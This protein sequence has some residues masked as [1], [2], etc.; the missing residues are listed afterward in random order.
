MNKERVTFFSIKQL[1]SIV[2]RY[3]IYFYLINIH[4]HISNGVR[5]HVYPMVATIDGF[6]VPR[7]IAII[8][9]IKK[10]AFSYTLSY[11]GLLIIIKKS[12]NEIIT[13]FIAIMYLTVG[14]WLTERRV[15]LFHSD[16]PWSTDSELFA[17]VNQLIHLPLLHQEQN[18]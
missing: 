5:M 7:Q 12:I 13:C 15:T 18:Y 9:N 17:A 10:S 16:V 11:I 4:K 2:L 1:A 3:N 8:Y 6:R 14:M